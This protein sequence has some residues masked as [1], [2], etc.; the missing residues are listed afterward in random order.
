MR[1]FVWGSTPHPAIELR[2]LDPVLAKKATF[3]KTTV[4]SLEVS[5]TR[6]FLAT[7]SFLSEQEVLR[8]HTKTSRRT[9]DEIHLF[10]QISKN[11]VYI[12]VC[13]D[14]TTPLRILSRA[15]S[16]VRVLAVHGEP[17]PKTHPTCFVVK[18]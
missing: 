16:R 14:M 8:P 9:C 18:D 7:A 17:R 10:L 1:W 15:C 3:F 5:R 4:L 11:R 6:G 13:R 12:F 2:P